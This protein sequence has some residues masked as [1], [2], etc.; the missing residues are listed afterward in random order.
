LRDRKGNLMPPIFESLIPVFLVTMI[1]WATRASGFITSEQWQGFERVTYYLLMPALII[2]T[3]AMTDLS[4]V[5]VLKVGISLAVPVLLMTA[6]LMIFR[7]T[8]LKQVNIEG[9]AFTSILQGIIRWNAFVGVALAAALYGNEGLAFASVALALIVPLV[10]LVSA[11]VLSKYGSGKTLEPTEFVLQLLKNPFIWSTILGGTIAAIGL[12]IP[13][14]IVT[15]TD[16]MG[17]AALAAGLLLVGSGLELRNV[18]NAGISLW[19]GTGLRLI[20]M[21]L[22]TG[23]IGITLGLTGASLLVPVICSAVP[24]A[25]SAYIMSRQNGGDAPLMASIITMQT[26]G[27]AA[28]IPLMLLLFGGR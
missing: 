16:I 28:T 22:L 26:L 7:T 3:L 18:R 15:T 6:L 8:L 20:V 4:R 2:V 1:G 25:A 10:N 17:R 21:P 13:K 23:G 9:P 12:P 27:A 19:L 5:P 11:Y 14:S 24:T